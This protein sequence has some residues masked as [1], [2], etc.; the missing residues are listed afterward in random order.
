MREKNVSL[1]A[2]ASRVGCSINTVSHALR[3]MDDI[4]ESLKIRIRKTA[5][6]MGYL[7]NHVAQKMG[8]DERFVVGVFADNFSNLYFNT[9]YGELLK[10]FRSRE[11]LDCVLML[12]EK[13][14]IEIIKKCIL[15]RVDIII[16]YT[17][18]DENTAEFAR[19]N[20]IRIIYAGSVFMYDPAR[21]DMDA[22]DIDNGYGCQLAAR[23]LNNFHTSEKFVFVGNDYI[24]SRF[25]YDA[26]KDEIGKI[27][28]SAQVDFYNI[29][30]DDIR[31][32]YEKILGG[33]RSVFCFNDIIAYEMLSKLDNLVVDVRRMF[34]DLHILGFDGLCKWI[35]GFQQIS[36]I[37]IDFKMFAEKVYEVTKFR[38]ENP[39]LPPVKVT[40]PVTLH[41]REK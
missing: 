35:E 18:C 28:S 1:K 12:S 2:I 9:L 22:V 27:N 6:E 11:E 26:F 21:L 17:V 3:D 20:N 5:I 15:Q 38:I 19:L 40:L 14:D 16:T 13:F 29:S 34:P 25:R 39:T 37:T 23:Y 24:F 8:K 7:P 33:Y 30:T 32:L 36:T 10:V 41:Q 31:V 4:S